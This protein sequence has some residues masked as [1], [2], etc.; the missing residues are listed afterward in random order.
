MLEEI[1]GPGQLKLS[2]VCNALALTIEA[3]DNSFL[4]IKPVRKVINN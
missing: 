1:G 2:L 4:S 3:V